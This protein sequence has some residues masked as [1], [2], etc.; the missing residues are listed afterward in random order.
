[1][2]E[3]FVDLYTRNGFAGPVGTI[4]R[5]HYAPPYAQVKG[6]YA[7]RR[8]DVHAVADEL[9]RGAGELPVAVLEGDDVSIELSYR[10]EGSSTAV[11]NVLADEIHYI[12]EGAGR[13]ETDFGVLDV[14][15]GDFV[16]LPRAVTYRFASVSTPIRE[17]VVVTASE[18]VLDPQPPVA[19]DVTQHVDIPEPNPQPR[20]DG[21]FEVIIRHG[22][23]T[24]IYTFDVDPMPCIGTGEGPVVRRFSFENVPH[25]TFEQTGPF[26]PKLFDDASSRVLM[27]NLSDRESPRPPIHHNA[28]FDELIFYVAGPGRYGEVDVPGTIMWTPK[29]IVHHGPAE[30]V[31]NGY[32]AFLVETRAAMR[33]TPAGETIATLMET[34]MF[35]LFDEN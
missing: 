34:G 33:L 18:M 11:R 31:P 35:G 7:P 28:D 27:F 24:T 25:L 23:D 19:L 12:L 3:P 13:L 9:F 20:Q 6:T 5:S 15:A 8:M 10:A 30:D 1:M 2:T 29:G 21:P 16:L 4:L 32:R 17:I 26:P 22:K 14:A